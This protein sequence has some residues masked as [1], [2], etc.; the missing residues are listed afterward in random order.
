MNLITKMLSHY[1]TARD[2]ES[3][4][5]TKLG[6]IVGVLSMSYRFVTD[7][8]A[9]AYEAYALGMAGLITAMAIKYHVEDPEKTDK[10][11]V[12]ITGGAP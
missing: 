4:S 10:K 5:L 12:N 6:F 9:P 2:G 7:I 3:F 8:S 11:D 1:L